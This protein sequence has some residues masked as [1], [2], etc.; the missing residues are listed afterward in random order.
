MKMTEKG[1][2][3]E[4]S[5]AWDIPGPS[6]IAA[7]LDTVYTSTTSENPSR[8]EEMECDPLF[9]ESDDEVEVLPSAENASARRASTPKN[10]I[11]SNYVNSTSPNQPYEVNVAS[12]SQPIPAHTPVPEEYQPL[13][14]S[15][16]SVEYGIGINN[17]DSTN[18]NGSRYQDVNMRYQPKPINLQGGYF[19][20]NYPHYAS[21]RPARE[22]LVAPYS[23]NNMIVLGEDRGFVNQPI[24]YTLSANR[25]PVIQD[26]NMPHV[27]YEHI[28]PNVNEG[29]NPFAGNRS[30]NES[31]GNGLERPS[32][33]L[34]ISPRRK[35]SK[36]NEV[37]LNLIEVSSE[38]E[39][40]SASQNVNLI[41]SSGRQMSNINAAGSS[42]ASI[43]ENVARVD[44]KRE[45][46][47]ETESLNQTNQ[48]QTEPMRTN[49]PAH[50]NHSPGAV[51]YKCAKH[52]HP[53]Q[54]KQEPHGCACR[55][56]HLHSC[57]HHNQN[58]QRS[59]PN[60]FNYRNGSH[61]H[62]PTFPCA[63]NSSA[64][65]NPVVA[66]I[67][68]EPSTHPVIKVESQDVDNEPNVGVIKV[69][70]A[71]VVVKSEPSVSS[72][73][74]SK[75]GSSSVQVKQETRC[76]DVEA[77]GDRRIKESSPQPGTSSGR[78]AQENS[79]SA[80]QSASSYQEAQRGADAADAGAGAGAGASG[81]RNVLSAPDLQLDWVSDSSSDDD[82]QL[83]REEQNTREVIDLT[84]SPRGQ[85]PE[86]ENRSR[87]LFE[88]VPHRDP[89]LYHTPPVPTHAHVLHR[90]RVRCLMACRG[91]CCASHGGHGH[92]HA[93]HGHTHGH[94]HGAHVPLAPHAHAPHTTHNPPPLAHLGERRRDTNP[95]APPYL[96]HE[97]LWHRQQHMLEV[98]RRSMMG[99]MSGLASG[100]S[101]YPPSYIS[102]RPNTMLA[103]PDDM[104]QPPSIMEGQ[105]VHHHMHHYLQMHPPHLHISIQ[106]SVMGGG[107]GATQMAA[108]VRVAEAAEARRAARGASRAV[109]ERNTYRHA[110]T[111][112]SNHRDDKCTI[113]LCVF[114]I[115]SD[116]RRLPCMHL[117]HME[118]VDQWLSTNK[119]C[120]ICRVDIE[121]HLNKD[122]TF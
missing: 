2:E 24:N 83:L 56:N 104:D 59:S 31:R 38:E 22:Y 66:N 96:V 10:A 57:S 75:Q 82:V 48:S 7:I 26:S 3:G 17:P 35:L 39:D 52:R 65:T 47:E 27:G 77:G 94:A 107:L 9:A 120:P 122:A 55:S 109:I 13:P 21:V 121:T 54:V 64:S 105:H 60:Y 45:P 19:Y 112:P 30:H 111:M 62:R 117:F 106:P 78:N 8:S 72:P 71:P 91:C 32:R 6:S 70:T 40:N 74:R 15:S 103:F 58:A 102:P 108:L 95:I 84:S 92:A 12:L 61:H 1:Y 97:R 113:C 33:K 50:Q 42:R 53:V 67:K 80:S 85:T 20:S 88:S 79:T 36:E 28:Q 115:D 68:E 44:V 18:I 4:Q 87:P 25:P 69:E 51:R 118:C 29:F 116:C 14:D 110:Y 49:R 99:D 23:T 73:Q 119:H 63:H 90:T 5:S 34:N 100:F 43:N 76:C 101:Q 114:E 16:S 41:D 11:S 86:V 46:Q 81:N 98:Q 93:A 89:P 37:N